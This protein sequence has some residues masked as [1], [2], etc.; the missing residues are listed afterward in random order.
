M[1]GEQQLQQMQSYLIRAKSVDID[2]ALLVVLRQ[3]A[4]REGKQIERETM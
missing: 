2:D 3:Q 1:V 4:Q